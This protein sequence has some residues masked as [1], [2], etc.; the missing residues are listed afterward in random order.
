[1]FPEYPRPPAAAAPAPVAAPNPPSRASPLP[2]PPPPSISFLVLAEGALLAATL[3]VAV[4]M[5]NLRRSPGVA[6]QPIP[7]GRSSRVASIP[8]QG[9]I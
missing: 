6:K 8:P 5:E 9:Q 2:L 4:A 1:M 7:L 3:P